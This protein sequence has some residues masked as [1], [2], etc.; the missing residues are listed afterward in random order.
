MKA[1]DLWTVVGHFVNRL[2]PRIFHTLRKHNAR[3]TPLRS[4]D[5]LNGLRGWAALLVYVSHH[6]HDVTYVPIE[7]AYG[8]DGVY[9]LIS[10]PFI[11]TLFTGSHMAVHIFFVLSGYVLSRRVLEMIH[12]DTDPGKI[13][14]SLASSLCRRWIRLWGPIVGTTFLAMTVQH[15]CWDK[16]DQRM[17]N[18]FWQ[19]ID[20]LAN[21]LHASFPFS[22]GQYMTSNPHT[23]TIPMEYKGS[24]YVFLAL[25][26][27]CRMTRK[28]RLSLILG[29]VSFIHYRGVWQ[30]STFLFGMVLSEIDM[31]D[32][33]SWPRWKIL[34]IIE[35]WKIIILS[36]MMIFALHCA[37]QPRRL[38]LVEYDEYAVSPGY[39]YMAILT[40]SFYREKITGGVVN[41]WYSI[42]AVI[43]VIV[44]SHLS[45]LKEVF[46]SPWLQ[47]L[48]QIS[49]GFYLVHGPI[50]V[51]VGTR[52]YLAVGA[53]DYVLDQYRSWYN[54]WEFGRLGPV[55]LRLNFLCCHLILLPLTLYLGDL[56]TEFM[57]EPSVRLAEWAYKRS[58]ATEPVNPAPATDLEA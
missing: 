23:W 34:S 37:G 13:T 44:V 36:S 8:R 57:D 42:G 27:T 20:W 38:M 48:G 14:T 7:L 1:A 54:I 32:H 16:P 49:Y 12:K 29:L 52:L 41:F 9:Y 11:R 35:K 46:E 51:T 24:I 4:T 30:A 56:V 47:Y 40:P 26:A 6:I 25:M 17:K 15:I 55:G 31:L 10:F 28:A 39:Q 53:R 5:Y 22:N 33:E 2:K 50:L 58:I 21:F 45:V 3:T 19:I 18:Y 43:T